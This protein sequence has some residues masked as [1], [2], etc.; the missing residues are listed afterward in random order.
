MSLKK[1]FF[2][3]DDLG[4]GVK[5]DNDILSAVCCGFI[6]SASVSVVNGLGCDHF[7]R[8]L[9][10]EQTLQLGLHINLTEGCPISDVQKVHA[11]VNAEGNFEPAL[12]LL[13]VESDLSEEILYAEMKNQFMRFKQ[14]SA[15]QPNHLDSHQ[16]YA[17]LSPV[18]FRA[19]LKLALS[20]NLKIRNPLPFINE[21]RLQY[22]VESVRQRYGIMIPFSPRKRAQELREIF[23]DSKVK[24]RTADCLTEI[25]NRM[26]LKK[27]THNLTSLE[28]VCHPHHSSDLSKIKL[29]I[30]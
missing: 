13:S 3:A 18:A 27:Y 1:I 7:K 6:Q 9:E 30:Q 23:E 17:Y 29:L 11:I 10:L 28:V 4:M 24:V 21:S 2:N 14:L 16:H 8:Y 22:F 15:R 12:H 26:N 19:F 25:P 20:E 5:I